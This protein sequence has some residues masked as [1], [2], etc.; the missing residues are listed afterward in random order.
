MGERKPGVQL[1]SQTEEKQK[2]KTKREVEIADD[3]FSF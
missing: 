2:R 1:D 3:R